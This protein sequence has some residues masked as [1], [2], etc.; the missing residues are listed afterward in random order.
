M[1]TMRD[2]MSGYVR[3]AYGLPHENL[4]LAE[5]EVPPVDAGQ[6]LIAVRATSVNAADWHMLTGTPYLLRLDQGLRRPKH[7][8]FGLDVAGTVVTVGADVTNLEVGDEVFGEVNGSYAEYAI[9]RAR[10]VVRKPRNVTFEQAAAVP[11]AGLTAL[12]GLRDH[13]RLEPGQHVLINGASGGVGTFAVQIAKALGADV[14][15]VVSTGNA[16]TATSLGADDVV[17]YTQAD[18]ADTAQRYDL[19]LDNV[20]NRPLATMRRLLTDSG[21]YVMVSGPKGRWLGPVPRMLR[22]MVTFLLSKRTFGWFVARADRD[23]LVFLGELLETGQVTPVIERTYPFAELPAA[24]AHLGEGH[25]RGKS[26]VSFAAPI[27]EEV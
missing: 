12:Q 14:T 19:I 8:P 6:V 11:V 10:N 4:E 24:L 9:A 23:D 16:A 1:Q 20:G 5:L 17:D 26:V 18:F 15:A 25:S 21:T 3:T 22:G 7:P 2:T 27:D 13:G